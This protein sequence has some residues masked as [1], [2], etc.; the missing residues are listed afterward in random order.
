MTQKQII[1]MASDFEIQW[2]LKEIDRINSNMC[3]K[4]VFEQATAKREM[5]QYAREIQE[6]LNNEEETEEAKCQF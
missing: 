2:R 5:K 3:H 1:R 4:T 6:I